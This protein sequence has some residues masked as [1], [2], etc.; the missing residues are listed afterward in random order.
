MATRTVDRSSPWSVA[1]W[2][3]WL[4]HGS[5]PKISDRILGPRQ[6]V[7]H[8]SSCSRPAADQEGRSGPPS[9]VAERSTWPLTPSWR[10]VPRRPACVPSSVSMTT[11]G[12]CAARASVKRAAKGMRR[13]LAFT[14]SS[15]CR[16][17][18]IIVPRPAGRVKRACPF[19]G[20]VT[21]TERIGRAMLRIA[22]KGHPVRVLENRD[23]N[24]AG[25]SEA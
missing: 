18:E 12:A 19:P 5:S 14:L 13:V 20:F 9:S 22:V 3:G 16:K 25:G 7:G 6:G 8:G 11:R 23:I 17:I 2:P 10:G 4:P 1:A 15:L 21:T 24:A